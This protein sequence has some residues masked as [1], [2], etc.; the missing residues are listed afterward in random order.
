MNQLVVRTKCIKRLSGQKGQYAIRAKWA[1][2]QSGLK[3]STG[4]QDKMSQLVIRI[5]CINNYQ[6]EMG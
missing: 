2:L 3:M 5:K 1:Y 6:W 4:H